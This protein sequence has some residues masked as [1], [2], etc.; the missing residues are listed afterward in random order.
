MKR[1]TV[2]GPDREAAC[3]FSLDWAFDKIV[4]GTRL[5]SDIVIHFSYT[6]GTYICI[7]ILSRTNK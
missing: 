6:D 3:Y 5:S 1:E 4:F 2:S 7:K